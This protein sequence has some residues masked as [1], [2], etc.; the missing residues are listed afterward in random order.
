MEETRYVNHIANRKW[1]QRVFRVVRRSIFTLIVRCRAAEVGEG[2][3]ANHYS[4]VTRNTYLAPH[5]SF[6]GIEIIGKAR[7]EIGQYFHSGGGCM[8]ITSN[9]NYEGDALPYDYTDIVKDVKIEDF[10]WIGNRVMI[11]PGV[12]IGEGAIVQAGAVVVNDVPPC[13]IVGGN[14][15]RVFKYRDREHFERLKQEMK[16]L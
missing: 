11:L 16:F 3:C 5:V 9:H 8:I 10:V 12:T 7:V 14:P 15:A 6:N 2:C 1:L 4:K 13:A